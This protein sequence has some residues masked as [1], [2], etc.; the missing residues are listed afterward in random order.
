VATLADAVA[1]TDGIRLFAPPEITVVCLASA[2]VDLFALAAALAARG[3][4]T[5]P[6]LSYGNPPPTLHLTVTAAIG[7]TAAEFAPDLADAV[8]AARARGPIDLPPELVG[9]AAALTPAMVTPALIEG[10][11]QGLGLAGGDFS[12][13]ATV[14]TL[15][16]AAPPALREALLT[17]FL[18]LLQRPAW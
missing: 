7:A 6:Q 4:H 12:Q 8:A 18:S 2:G 3:W 11:A 5:Q 16:D 14:N 1:A 9:T 13:M 10:L 17:G 15:L